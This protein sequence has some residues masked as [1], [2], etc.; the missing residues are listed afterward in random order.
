MGPLKERGPRACCDEMEDEL[1]GLLDD[2]W[3]HFLG[4]DSR[5]AEEFVERIEAL[6]KPRPGEESIHVKRAR[7][8]SA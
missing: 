1:Y 6:A 8:A 3:S 5:V 7:R 4:K 2:L